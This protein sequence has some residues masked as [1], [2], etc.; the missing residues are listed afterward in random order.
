MLP[1]RRRR[2]S[3]AV[4][5]WLVCQRQR[6]LF[7][8]RSGRGPP[9]GKVV[10]FSTADTI[11]K[12]EQQNAVGI[13]DCS[14]FVDRVCIDVVSFFSW[15]RWQWIGTGMANIIITVTRT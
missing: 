7:I 11:N 6:F 14:G 1:G 5:V 13:D 12:I 15:W 3:L 8:Q 10:W 9:K 2:N 4:A